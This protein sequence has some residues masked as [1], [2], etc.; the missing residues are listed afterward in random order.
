MSNRLT[1]H[2]WSAYSPFAKWTAILTLKFDCRYLI[3]LVPIPI[4][5][6]AVV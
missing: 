4:V 1:Q 2:W 6:M 3:A 5:G